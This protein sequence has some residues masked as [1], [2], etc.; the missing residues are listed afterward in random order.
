MSAVARSVLAFAFLAF[1][2]GP[3]QA[4]AIL[5]GFNGSTLARNDD[6]STGPVT[7]PFS[8]NFFGLN[9]DTV[10]V[11]NNGNLTFDAALETFTPF[12]LTST[13][14]QI[15][16]PFFADVETRFAGSPVTYGA[17]TVDGRTAFGVNWIN[18]DYFFSAPSHTNRNS[19]QL[20]LIDRAD[21]A[22]G[23]FDFWF[24]YD[25]IQ[26]EAGQ[27]SGGDAN[28]R[29]GS[30][31][32]AGYANGNSAT[33]ELPGSGVCGAFLDSGT[34]AVAPV[35]NALVRNSLNS[36]VAGRYIFNVR[37]GLVV[38]PTPTP[39]P[40]PGTMLL[41]GSGLAAIAARARKRRQGPRD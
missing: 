10:F 38:D 28:G 11:N 15:I 27:A 1:A 34:P 5:P 24:N 32:R 41:L 18:V 12:P 9:D 6:G 26:W 14:R 25:L 8:V 3:V 23:D 7:L 29:G 33:L 17:G 37:N 31:A 39:I 19:F 30:C 16:A 40:E 20:L 35:P 22:A 4:A 36:N 21:V 2:A 13:N